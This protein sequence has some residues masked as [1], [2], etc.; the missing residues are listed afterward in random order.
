VIPQSIGRCAA[1]VA[2]IALHA[3]CLWALLQV[4]A[5]RSAVQEVARIFVTF[6]APSP[7]IK[8]PEPLPLAAPEPKPEPKPI[9]S[10]KPKP[11]PPPK[12]PDPAPIVAAETPA[13]AQVEVA[14]P[15]PA[16]RVEPSASPPV[17]EPQPA[18]AP[19][20]LLEPPRFDMAYLNNPAPDYPAF[21]RRL[22]EQGR[23]LLRV[24]VNVEG[25]AEQVEIKESSG[26]RRLDQA[27]LEAVKKWRFIPAKR[28]DQP[29]KG[30]AL[31]PIN[32][33]LS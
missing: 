19:P 26:S 7:E 28:A 21:S 1:F 4:E 11:A 17:A 32:F 16:P 33:Q 10:T 13:P 23:V 24:L 5:V 3:A 27:A 9:K 25:I 30:R 31:V 22:G 29:I 15:E 2:V 12:K 6:V 14:Q 8:P 18:P 20:P